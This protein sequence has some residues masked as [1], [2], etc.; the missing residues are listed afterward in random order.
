MN[1]TRLFFYLKQA[2]ELSGGVDG[3]GPLSST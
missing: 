2:N 1:D 3:I